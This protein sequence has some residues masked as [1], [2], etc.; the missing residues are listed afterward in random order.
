MEKDNQILDVLR[1]YEYS[2]SIGKSLNYNENCN[3]FLK[4]LLKRRN[5]NACW[6]LKLN[7]KKNFIK[8]YS[9][10]Y[11][12]KVSADLNPRLTEFLCAIKK[13]E[14][15]EYK[16]IYK[17]L[18]TI[19]IDEGNIAIFKLYHHNYLFLYSKTNNISQKDLDQLSPVINKFSN[20]LEACKAYENQ[21]TLLKRLKERN[22][23]LNNYAHIISHD[24]RSPLR[25]IETLITW[26]KEDHGESLDQNAH[27]YINS[28]SENI[29][30][31]ESLVSGILE[32]STI[33]LKNN[34]STL[35]DLNLIIKETLQHIHIPE[36]IN[37]TIN[38]NFPTIE[39]NKFRLQQL[40]QN[41]LDNAIKYNDKETGY[42]EIGF[43]KQQNKYVYFV[44]D[45]G[46][47]IDKKYHTKIFSVFQRLET[48]KNSTGIGLSIVEKIVTNYGG[49]I[50]LTSEVSK[51][52]TFFFTLEG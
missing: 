12:N 27:K 38:D 13:H 41:L 23:E 42:I 2:M 14:L 52:T 49:E 32:Y 3:T 26:L 7:K 34:N 6:I 18:T 10:P 51:G 47:G 8:K 16:P 4:L 24:L 43:I 20:T 29:Y 44:R 48:N 25:N 5:L 50:W 31:M 21:K 28:I 37:I 15:I 17:Q 30:R 33:S 45:N 19:E 1:L 36:H 35:V 11:G 40:F 39:G 22:K 9:V 46:I